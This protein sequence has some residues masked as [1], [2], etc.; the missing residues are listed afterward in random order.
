MKL[1]NTQVFTSILKYSVYSL[2][3]HGRQHALGAIMSLA[4]E[5]DLDVRTGCW[6]SG[7]LL[8]VA[9]S[10]MR[11][12]DLE[13]HGTSVHFYAAHIASYCQFATIWIWYLFCLPLS[14]IVVER[15]KGWWVHLLASCP[16]RPRP[17]SVFSAWVRPSTWPMSGSGKNHTAIFV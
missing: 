16:C 10:L 5:L 1:Q 4:F 11:C 6:H 2:V 14:D 13:S 15:W 12:H 17:N 3:F 8:V 7:V 9:P